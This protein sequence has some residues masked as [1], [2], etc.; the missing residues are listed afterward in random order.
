MDTLVVYRLEN[1][2]G[3]GPFSYHRD[4]AEIL[5]GHSNP[6]F[7]DPKLSKRRVKDFYSKGWRFAWSSKETFD[8]WVGDNLEIFEELGYQLKVYYVSQYRLYDKQQMWVYDEE[9]E[10]YLKHDVDGFQVIF[11]PKYA[12]EIDSGYTKTDS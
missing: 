4:V 9:F 7:A 5:K 1:K 12:K 10:D 3:L 8:F 11:N 2:D 6:L